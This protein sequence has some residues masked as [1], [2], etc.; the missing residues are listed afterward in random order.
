MQSVGSR[1]RDAR[2]MR[3]LSIED[4]AQITKISR[5][6]LQ[7][8]E[9]DN[10]Q[11]LPAPVFARGFVRCYGAAVGLDL[12]ELVR[13]LPSSLDVVAMRSASPRRRNNELAYLA[14]HTG[15][16][17]GLVG[18]SSQLL[19]IFV[20]IS[21]LLAAWWM[22]GAN[23]DDDDDGQAA[24]SNTPRIERNIRAVPSFSDATPS[25]R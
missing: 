23:K 15:R 17:E 4:L 20:A 21:M 13:A 18:R 19:L 6:Y 1:L 16:G 5:V 10:F 12:N 25:R 11:V 14:G 8:I 9:A 24:G 7:A 3:G 2:E 22:V